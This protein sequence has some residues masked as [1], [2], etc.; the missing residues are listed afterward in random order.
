MDNQFSRYLHQMNQSESL[1]NHR[2]FISPN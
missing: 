2:P 1:K